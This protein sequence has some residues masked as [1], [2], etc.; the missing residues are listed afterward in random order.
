MRNLGLVKTTWKFA[1][2]QKWT[3]KNERQDT[4]I[5]PYFKK[6]ISL[7]L[8]FRSFHKISD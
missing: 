4:Q 2:R 1:E 3:S 6:P 7:L 8:R 5:T